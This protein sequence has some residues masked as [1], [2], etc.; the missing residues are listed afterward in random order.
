MSLVGVAFVKGDLLYL[1][2]LAVP[3]A[4][5]FV[6]TLVSRRRALRRFGGPGAALVSSSVPRQTARAVL[7]L[8][9]TA[10][11]VVALAGPYV[12]E[13]EVEVRWRGVDL[14]IALDVSQSMGVQDVAP[15]RLRLSRGAIQSLA[16][17]VPGSRVALVLF[18]ASGIVR[19]PATTDP[20]VIGGVLDS[21]GRSFR[22]KAGSSLQEAIAASLDAFPP[23]GAL[24][25]A[26][27]LVSDGEDLGAQQPDPTRLR[28][29][30]VRLFALAVGTE[31][32]GPVP[33]YDNAGKYLGPLLGPGN[34]P[35]V[36]RM[37]VE[38]LRRLAEATG[39]TAW[40]YEG[41][42][43]AVGELAAAITAMG[44][45]ELTG[46]TQTAPDDR[47]QLFGVLAL[48]LLLV[49]WLVSDRRAMPRPG[50]ARLRVSR[51][52]AGAGAMLV[53]VLASCGDAAATNETANGLF[54]AGDLPGALERYKALLREHPQIPELS[55]NAGNTLHRMGDFERA[56]PNYDAALTARERT[57]RAVALYDK[58]NT[59]FRLGRLDEAREAY[60]AALRLT[61]EDRDA[62]FNIE[63]I[64][65]RR[66][67]EGQQG[68][69][70]PGDP[71]PGEPGTSPAPGAPGGSPP[72]S[73]GQG[74]PET[75]GPNQPDASGTPGSPGGEGRESL[76]E[77]LAEFKESLTPEEALR[78]LDALL[79][80]QRGLETILEGG[81]RRGGPVP[82]Y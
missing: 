69:P 16:E 20:R 13:R 40:R 74:T 76:D 81:P 10:A 43:R 2:L 51:R 41:D 53:L 39:G 64:D 48:G 36:S 17:Q 44:S 42:D 38:T 82:E 33:A 6:V 63:V 21:I 18:G 78:V 12:D 61:P 60:V 8:A 22:P 68:A 79:R 23:E 77:A 28:A 57:V 37:H 9:A 5:L 24:P 15:D 75:G 52:S 25:E 26:V 35:I 7:V 46:A 66:A 65:R 49:E 11:L 55:V 3:L 67:L 34:Q 27:V 31:V 72:P 45:G 50:R 54:A 1:L 80:E 4:A 30:G 71:Q 70:R 58:G 14:V 59:L 62:K 29:R 19:Y 32:G 47:Y 56:I 73:G